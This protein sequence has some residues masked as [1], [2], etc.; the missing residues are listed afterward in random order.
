MKHL[1]DVLHLSTLLTGNE[2]LN[3]P[4][5]VKAD[6]ASFI[7]QYEREPYNPKQLGLLITAA[8]FIKLM[9]RVFMS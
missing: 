3:L 2:K 9:H 7:S 4:E 8:E 6:I 5:T 1:K